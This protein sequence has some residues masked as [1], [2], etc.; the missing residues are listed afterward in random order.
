M[1]NNQNLPT[2]AELPTRPPDGADTALDV[3][4]GHWRDPA[5]RPRLLQAQQQQQ[6]QNATGMSLSV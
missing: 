4:F 1:L 5:D 3:D 6:Q 2:Y